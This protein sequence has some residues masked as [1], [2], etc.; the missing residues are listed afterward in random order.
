[1]LFWEDGGLRVRDFRTRRETPLRPEHVLLLDFFGKPR[2][3][4]TAAEVAFSASRTSSLIRRL[5]R[6]GVLVS[7]AE[8]RR[9]AALLKLWKNNLGAA[10]FHGAIRDTPYLQR[11][12][13]IRTYLRERV[14]EEK[15]PP[16]FKRY[17]SRFRRPLLEP[18]TAELASTALG[19]VLDARRTVRSFSRQPVPF[20]DFAAVL[21]GT[22][23]QTGWFSDRIVGRLLTKTSPSSGS[24]HSIECYVLVWNVRGLGKGLYHYDVASDELRRL[25]SGDFRRHAVRAASG[26][27]WIQTGA[28]LC[29]MAPVFTRNLWKYPWDRAYR[30]IWLDA[31]HLAQTFSLLATARGLGPF[32]TAAIQDSYIERL[33]GLDGVTEFPIY[34]CGAG[35]PARPLLARAR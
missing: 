35:I 5:T 15:R 7:E 20:D 30:S 26:Q 34:L 12:D 9:R 32:T 8:G 13:A 31:G 27:S 4:T 11:M 21:G 17:R 29:V 3:P 19:T 33:I 14:A 16:S 25:R 18:D 2:R 1:L 22:W 10:H 23:G 28:F 24:L 6:S